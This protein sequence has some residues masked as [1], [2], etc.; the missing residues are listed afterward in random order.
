SGSGKTTSNATTAAPEL[1]RWPWSRDK[2]SDLVDILF[3]HYGAAVVAFDVVFPE[4]DRSS[5]LKSLKALADGALKDNQAFKRSLDELEPQLDY[6]GRFEEA[7]AARPVVLG[8]YFSEDAS[9]FARH[10]AVR[11]KNHQTVVGDVFK[12]PN[13]RQ[14]DPVQRMRNETGCESKTKQ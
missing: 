14:L 7:I 10:R 12:T 4:P 3:D 8:Y 2:M 6:D 5:G 9:A 11:P 1:G 13:Q